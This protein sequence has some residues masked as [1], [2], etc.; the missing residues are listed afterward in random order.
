[1][2]ATNQSQTV[3]S[4][5]LRSPS[6]YLKEFE[7]TEEVNIREYRFLSGTRLKAVLAPIMYWAIRHV[8]KWL[9]LLP[10]R[11]LVFILRLLY[12]WSN[13]P[14]RQSCEYIS[15]LASDAGLTH[16]PKAIYRQLLR[17]AAGTV[18]DYFHLYRDGIDSVTGIIDLNSQ[19]ADRINRLAKEYGGVMIM[20]PHNFASVFSAVKMNRAFPL[21]IVTRNSP[22][23]DRTKAAL[24]FFERMGVTVLMVRGGNPFEL[25]RTLFAELKK[26]TAVAATVDSIDHASQ[27]KVRMFGQEVGF[28]SWAAKIAVKKKV[29]IIPSYFRSEGQQVTALFGEEIVTDN[30]ETAM[31]HYAGFFERQILEDPASWAYLGDKRWRRLLQS[32]VGSQ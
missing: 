32:A 5:V 6:L 19:D 21:L 1:M 4:E 30:L 26:G 28:A 27:A 11:L 16:S 17:N 9:A 23:I 31:Q 10:I 13:N 7:A 24:D 3:R 22:T 18:E 20:V 2:D 12:V 14:F 15:R 8:P 29:P 25:S